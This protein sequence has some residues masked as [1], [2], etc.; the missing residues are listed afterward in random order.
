MPVDTS[1]TEDACIVGRRRYARRP[2][3]D[4]ETRDPRGALDI[5]MDPR[6]PKPPRTFRAF[7]PIAARESPL[8]RRARAP[9]PLENNFVAPSF[10]L[11]L[12]LFTRNGIEKKKREK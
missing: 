1:R 3:V 2:F 7:T 6:V 11:P 12:L 9:S 10:S 5:Q 4:T 8:R